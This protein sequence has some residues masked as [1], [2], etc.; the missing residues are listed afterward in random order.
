[1]IHEDLAKKKDSKVCK[2]ITMQTLWAG[3]NFRAGQVGETSML[4][5]AVKNC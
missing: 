2:A 1:M 4:L 5:R 3:G